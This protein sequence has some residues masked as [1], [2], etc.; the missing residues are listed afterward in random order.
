MSAEVENLTKKLK[1]FNKNFDRKKY[2]VFMPHFCVDILVKS[3]GNLDLNKSTHLET[4]NTLKEGGKA[5][6][7]AFALGALGINSAIIAK[8]DKIGYTLLKNFKSKN[9]LKN[10]DISHVKVNGMPASTCAVEFRGRN[11]MLSDAGS[12]KNF[13]PEIL[14]ES[15]FNIIKHASIVAISD[16]ALNEKGTELATEIFKFAKRN[17][18]KT[19]FDPGDPTPKIKKAKKVDSAVNDTVNEVAKEI[20][21]ILNFVDF[22]GVNE[23]E[24]M[25]YKLD[26]FKGKTKIIYHTANFSSVIEENKTIAKANAFALDI[27]QLTGAGDVFNSGFIFGEIGNFEENEKLILAN[28]AAGCYISNPTASYANKG[29]IIK[30]LKTAKFKK[31]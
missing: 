6:N 17:N 10:L 16:W 7:S 31:I 24:F 19:F 22:L 14:T 8:T 2:V 25:R 12:L 9:N 13:G 23:D 4:K 27:H 21:E 30:F 26:S 1:N 29:N 15:D 3:E 20:K 11:I 18:V 28:A 5:T